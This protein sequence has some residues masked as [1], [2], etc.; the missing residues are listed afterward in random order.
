MELPASRLYF[1]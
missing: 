1:L